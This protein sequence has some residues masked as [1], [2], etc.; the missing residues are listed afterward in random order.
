MAY[1]NSRRVSLG[2]L[3][4]APFE[5]LQWRLLL[6][7]LLL[8]LVPAV[9]VALPLLHALGGLLDHSVH[10]GDWARQFDGIMFGDTV[11]ELA[12]SHGALSGAFFAALALTLL[13]QPLLSGMVVASG[14]AGRTLGFGQLLQS[15]VVEYG[16]MFRLTLW[17]LAIYAAAGF[18]V[19]TGMDVLDDKTEAATLETKAESVKHLVLWLS[20][21]C[22]VLAQVIVESARA[23]YIADSGLRSATVALGRGIGQLLRRPVSSLFA[24][25]LVSVI[26]FA[27]AFVLGVAR[28]HTT[29]VGINLLFAFLLSQLVVLALGWTR[30]ARLYALAEV[31]RSVGGGRR[32]GGAPAY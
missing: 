26:G 24:Y 16:R 23:A 30:I 5:A 31:A 6:L 9:M 27:V 22:L 28:A 21:L 17:A 29:A 32:V 13:L 11:R 12:D 18:L 7:W 20:G 1:K 4:R 8:M 14:R 19:K 15:G 3:L 2:A 10:A 25:L